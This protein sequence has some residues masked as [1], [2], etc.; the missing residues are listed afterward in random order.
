MLGHCSCICSQAPEA[1][2]YSP[3]CV[4]W[5]KN[6]WTSTARSAPVNSRASTSCSCS[7][8]NIQG[9]LALLHPACHS[10]QYQ[11]SGAGGSIAA[12]TT[13]QCADAQ[14]LQEGTQTQHTAVIEGCNCPLW[15]EQLS[16]YHIANQDAV[17][18]LQV[19]SNHI[20]V[21]DGV[22]SCS[23]PL[24]AKGGQNHSMTIVGSVS[25][26]MLI[27]TGLNIVLYCVCRL[28]AA[29]AVVQP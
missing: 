1:L 24:K 16:P 7:S 19:S 17:L 27:I 22:S 6:N 29:R 3:Y 4:V 9:P 8:N 13:A 28:E 20:M 5:L 14:R 26:R 15:C 2:N 11:P 18:R 10:Q 12:C 25:I 23:G 21:G